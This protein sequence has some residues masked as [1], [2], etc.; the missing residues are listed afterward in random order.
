MIKRHLLHLK[1]IHMTKRRLLHLI[2]SH[3]CLEL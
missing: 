3:K 1:L 2:R